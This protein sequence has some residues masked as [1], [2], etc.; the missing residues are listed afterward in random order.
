MIDFNS[1]P[2]CIKLKI[3]RNICR[4]CDWLSDKEEDMAIFYMSLVYNIANEVQR[5]P[6]GDNEYMKLLCDYM[7]NLDRWKKKTSSVW[8]FLKR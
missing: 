7:T 2:T 1:R 3:L 8:K 5:S 4:L 6:G